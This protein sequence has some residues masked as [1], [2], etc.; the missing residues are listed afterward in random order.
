MMDR[1]IDP[2][3]VAG[4][5]Q[6]ANGYLP[7]I[8]QG[9]EDYLSNRTHVEKLEEAYRFTHTI[10]GASSMLGF[11]NLSEV[12]SR[13]ENIMQDLGDGQLTVSKEIAMSLRQAAIQLADHLDDVAA[14]VMSQANPPVP[15]LSTPEP[16]TGFS[17]P[18]QPTTDLGVGFTLLDEELPLS[19]PEQTRP[20]VYL[21]KLDD[22]PLDLLEDFPDQP[23]SRLSQAAALNLPDLMTADD[24]LNE[25]E[26]SLM[27]EQTVAA[28]DPMVP[29]FQF[30]AGSHAA[31]DLPELPAGPDFA[32]ASDFL[33]SPDFDF[34]TGPLS[35]LPLPSDLG[36]AELPPAPD[37]PTA[38]GFPLSA[39]DSFASPES[40]APSPTAPGVGEA[41]SQGSYFS[42]EVSAELAEVFALEA[43][44]HLRHMSSALQTLDVQPGDQELIQS[45]RR[46]A[47]SLKGAAAMVGFR[48]ITQL[49]HR[50]EDLLDL[51]YEGRLG[52]T[53][54]IHRLLFVSTDT[55]EDLSGG[56]PST[57]R[58]QSLYA[59]Y[60]Q[61]LDAAPAES[62]RAVEL[63][64]LGELS[65][66]FEMP[67]PM[68]APEPVITPVTQ[69]VTETVGEAAEPVVAAPTISLLPLVAPPVA[70]RRIENKVAL[71]PALQAA[72]D[73]AQNPQN[74][75]FVRLPIGRLDELVRL[76][77]EL[78]IT[79]TSFEQRMADFARQI[80]DLRFSSD[81]LK[82]ISTQIETQYE[83]STLGGNE[84]ELTTAFAGAGVGSALLSRTT[85]GF[86]ALEFDRYTEFHLLSRELAETTSDAQTVGLELSSLLGDFDSFLNRQSRLNREIQDKLMR[87]RMVPLA[88][89]ATRLH[90]TVRNVAAQQGKQVEL[91]L[92]GEEVELDK[93]V[94]E[95]L[96][97]P[98]Q[99]LLRNAV[100][101]G[102]E[103]PEL[104]D[105][106]DKAPKGLIRISAYTEGT[107]VIIQIQDDGHGLDPDK[108]R[109]TAVRHEVI[110]SAEAA[111]MTDEA[112][113]SLI[114]LPGFS[115]S[116]SV[117]EISGRGV[118]L[119]VVQSAV[120]RL[121]GSISIDSAPGIGTA[122]TIRLPMTMAVT[123]GLMVKSG[124]QSYA[125]PLGNVTQI[126]RINE[127]QIE[128][129][130]RSPVINVGGQVSPLLWLSQILGSEAGSGEI[131]A[132]QP[133]LI[134]KVDG[135]QI[136]LA[137]D[138]ILGGREIVVKNLGSHLRKVHGVLGATLLGDGS[139]VLILNLADLVRDSLRR[140]GR[141]ALR[142]T[143][144]IQQL[145]LTRR[146][147]LTEMADAQSPEIP[148]ASD[149]A[150]ETPAEPTSDDKDYAPPP[151]ALVERMSH[152]IS[153]M[154]V[155]DSPSVRRVS[156]GLIR[157]V[158]W[159]ARQARDGLEALENLQHTMT[160]PDLLLLDIEMP[161][162]D[163][164][165]LLA[166][167]RAQPAW[168]DLPIVMVTSRASARHRQK[169]IELGATDYLIKPY[170]GDEL[171]SLIRRLVGEA[172]AMRAQA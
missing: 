106:Q 54:E 144:P 11:T 126:L 129:V 110:S 160:R 28:E 45:L 72:A 74:N 148:A 97:D 130:G 125:I 23:A 172:K 158:G 169:A 83:A 12:A 73:S 15:G 47:H 44:D 57:E 131:L 4:F 142:T 17:S 31:P 1:M 118:G 50:M 167:L 133:A 2:E 79:R 94:L 171:I 63:P 91:I 19:L 29:E 123:Q 64:I 62:T 152:T 151:V 78:V 147:S 61:L 108:I 99:H 137:V 9:I 3:V 161:R 82:R 141:D 135:R 38:A 109:A 46:S 156:T 115:T 138:Q 134:L 157:S 5:I 112:L 96:S 159:N 140:A 114:F 27:D 95:E 70:A 32:S 41:D 149:A 113:W 48:E 77:T 143:S 132:R 93:T 102:I 92:S 67:V 59:E 90:R 33:S 103:A 8:L 124:T 136:A 30:G 7:D 35:D 162:M 80:D 60:A 145:S 120:T 75:Q 14:S 22:E 105:H 40:F 76:A 121:K 56:K 36:R 170:Q 87:M 25:V 39:V 49:A 101:H 98:L 127:T 21:P 68:P 166:A 10:K 128:S 66:T 111:E 71:T 42:A 84:G 119:D 55:L 18:L 51:V 58:L 164:Y 139:V 88:T 20:G 154:V 37:F 155:D 150:A 13:L 146:L 116:Q 6:E 52:F 104:R 65:P 81:R 165:Q 100:D 153:V 24:F 117:S 16:A 86:D 43:E 85:H 122:F 34:P 163:G 26:L 69:T 107:Q 53:G 89:L 168:R